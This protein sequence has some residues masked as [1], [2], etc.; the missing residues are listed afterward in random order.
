MIVPDTMSDLVDWWKASHAA[1]DPREVH[2]EFYPMRDSI[3]FDVYG[4]LGT[5]QRGIRWRSDCE[6]PSQVLE[7]M[8]RR[9]FVE[10]LD[11]IEDDGIQSALDF[12]LGR[13]LFEGRGYD[14]ICEL[15]KSQ[16]P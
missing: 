7:T 2:Y 10:M 4:I 8:T 16:R 1:D 14:K 15:P 6:V 12:P 5:R 11:G 9:E 3:F 13:N